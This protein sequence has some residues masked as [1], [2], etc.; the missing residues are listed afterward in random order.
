M[1]NEYKTTRIWVQTLRNLKRISAETGETIVAVLDRL[2]DQ[3]WQRVRKE[4]T[5]YTYRITVNEQDL[6]R[7]QT[8]SYDHIGFDDAGNEIIEVTTERDVSTQLD[9]DPAVIS[10]TVC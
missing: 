8:V 2:A 10:Y 1:G 5:M 3:E 4:Q 6:T 7:I 9:S